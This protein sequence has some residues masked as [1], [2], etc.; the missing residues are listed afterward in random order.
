MVGVDKKGKSDKPLNPPSAKVRY[1]FDELEKPERKQRAHRRG[2]GRSGGAPAG[3]Q[4]GG[5]TTVRRRGPTIAREAGPP[6][7]TREKAGEGGRALER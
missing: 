4:A 6:P 7:P 5:A 2:P 3:G 1:F